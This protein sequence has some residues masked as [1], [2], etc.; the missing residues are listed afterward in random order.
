MMVIMIVVMVI[1]LIDG[2]VY[3][4]YSRLK[5]QNIYILCPHSADAVFDYMKFEQ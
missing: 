3:S 4:I 2:M 5:K 1:M